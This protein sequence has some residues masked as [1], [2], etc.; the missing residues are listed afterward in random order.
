MIHH[1][2]SPG[3]VRICETIL[4][5]RDGVEQRTGVAIISQV[6]AGSIEEATFFGGIY[7]ELLGDPVKKVY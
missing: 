6:Q 7:W 1:L 4:E 2:A 3:Y 5:T